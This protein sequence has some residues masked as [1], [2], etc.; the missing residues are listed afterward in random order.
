MQPSFPTNGMREQR[1]IHFAVN[2]TTKEN[3]KEAPKTENKPEKNPVA[4]P[5]AETQQ[6]TQDAERLLKEQEV[7]I[8]SI[9]GITTVY[10]K[11]ADAARA[12]AELNKIQAEAQKA[13]GDVGASGTGGEKTTATKADQ[14]KGV[15]D[16]SKTAP[17]EGNTAANSTDPLKATEAPAK[18]PEKKKLTVDELLKKM[19]DA[20]KEFQEAPQDKKVSVGVKL[21]MNVM[22]VLQSFM[23]GNISFDSETK[24]EGDESMKKVLTLEEALREHTEKELNSKDEKPDEQ[25]P[26]LEKLKTIPSAKITVSEDADQHVQEARFEMDMNGKGAKVIFTADLKGNIWLD[27]STDAAVL[28]QFKNYVGE[29]VGNRI[30]VKLDILMKEDASKQNPAIQPVAEAMKKAGNAK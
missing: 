2:N 1:L 10:G 26:L 15:V 4:D 24:K 25:K 23:K 30:P 17:S 7:R 28:D 6:R 5:K 22:V 8:A 29:K 11:P 12:M 19:N 21:A 27:P 9:N 16:P 13:R 3:P 20:W 18:A 14:S